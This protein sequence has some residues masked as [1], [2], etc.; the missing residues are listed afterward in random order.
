[1]LLCVQ[2]LAN[3]GPLYYSFVTSA[4]PPLLFR[5]MYKKSEIHT[6]IIH[7][8]DPL[9]YSFMKLHVYTICID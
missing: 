5:E 4:P 8:S 2:V 6:L 1:M 9:L 7:T 3:K